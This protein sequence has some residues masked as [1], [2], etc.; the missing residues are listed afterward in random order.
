MQTIE[1]Q[2]LTVGERLKHLRETL[3]FNQVEF[4]ERIEMEQSY[5]S[6][7]EKGHKG[8]GKRLLKDM[9]S[10][11]GFNGDW[12]MT[13]EGEMFLK[14]T[15]EIK[16]EMGD[17]TQIMG[18]PRG[19]TAYIPERLV[20]IPLIDINARAGFVENL[21]NYQEFISDF[22]YIEP[23]WGVKYDNAISVTLDGDSMEPT[24]QRGDKVLAFFQ[25]NAEWEY[26]NPGVYAIVYRNSFVIKRI[27]KNTLQN[28]GQLE[29]IS[30]NNIHGPI[31]VKIE[32]IKAIW[33]VTDL[34]RRR[35]H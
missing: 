20:K 34:I 33:K 7:L 9:I 29:L 26:L 22:I 21:D 13:G 12:L 5:L 19:V 3:G 18:G 4:A 15:G 10:T 25:E 27:V 17:M 31:T 14:N 35:I 28:T 2:M 11:F 8:L 16:Q 6:K 24:M 32:D 23:E 30:D 1:M